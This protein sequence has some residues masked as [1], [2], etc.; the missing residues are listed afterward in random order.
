MV[1]YLLQAKKTLSASLCSR[2][3]FTWRYLS[4]F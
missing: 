1:L 3:I 2:G 4:K